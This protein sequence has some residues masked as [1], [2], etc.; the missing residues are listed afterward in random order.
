PGDP[1]DSRRAPDAAAGRDLALVVR[2]G[3]YSVAV[4]VAL[5]GLHGAVAAAS[6]SLAVTAELL[7]NFVDL[8]SAAVVVV[9][10]KLAMRKSR[11]FPYGLYKIENLVAAG[12]AVMIFLTAYEI[13]SSVFVEAARLPRVD[14]WMLVFLVVTL[15]I[16]LVFSHAEMR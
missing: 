9:G 7:H 14:A 13:A 8:A 16:P 5:V 11:A 15:A 2:W 4:N 6:G 12:I 10:L 3:W 1:T